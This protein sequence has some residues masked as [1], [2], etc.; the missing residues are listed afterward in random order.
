MLQKFISNVSYIYS[1][2][3]LFVHSRM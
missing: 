2:S 3:C 1:Y